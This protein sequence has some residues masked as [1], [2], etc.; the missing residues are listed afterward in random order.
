MY[1]RSI[2]LGLI[3]VFLSMSISIVHAQ[4]P[5][6]PSYALRGP[7][8]VGTRDYVIQD[9]ERPLE[10]TIWYPAENPD[11]LP[12]ETVYLEGTLLALDGNALRDAP[13]LIG[14]SNYPLVLFSHGSGGFRL[15]SRFLTEHLASH[16]FVV[17]APDHPGNTILDV[18][19]PETFGQDLAPN[20]VY[21]PQDMNSTIDFVDQLRSSDEIGTIINM[22]RIAVIGHSFGGYTAFATSGVPLNFN[23][24][25]TTCE[26]EADNPVYGGVCFMLE[27]A[28]VTRIAS[29]NGTDAL[30]DQITPI[31]PD[32][33][34]QAVI[35]F[36]PWNGPILDSQT[37]NDI[38]I[39]TLIM[40]GTADDTTPPERD[41]FYIYEQ[42]ESAPKSLITFDNGG[43]YLFV[44]ECWELAINLGFF[45]SCSD[46]VWDMTRVHDI[47]NHVT[48]A[49]LLAEFAN[50]ADARVA[51]APDQIDFIGV[52]YETNSP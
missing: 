14:D 31:T 36:A 9:N 21:R 49:F 47:T 37:L 5:D 18:L 52:T 42:L 11:N 19:S 48:T 27:D 40:V 13:P 25:G 8:A 16:G 33:R 3:L 4:R 20:F 12:E 15:Q 7:Y 35:A 50:D 17:V 45:E 29:A 6:A 2:S 34:I 46:P 26:A 30:P 1:K 43:H 10:L 22:D 44:D 32:E 24:L 38:T 28:V 23:E 39:P 51:L 41:A